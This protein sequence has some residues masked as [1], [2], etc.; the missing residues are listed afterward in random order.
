MPKLTIPFFLF[1]FI[2]GALTGLTPFAVDMYIP[3]I[4]QIS[5]HISQSE[6]IT[7]LSITIFLFISAITQLF[8]G[9][10]SDSFGRRKVILIGICIFI[11]A[12]LLIVFIQN[13]TQLLL[14]RA[15]QAAGGG[16]IAV[17]VNAI[18]RD[19]YND[20]QLAKAMSYLIMIV[21][22]APMIAPI[23]GGLILLRFDWQMIFYVIAFLAIVFG[24]GFYFFIQESHPKSKRQPFN[25]KGIYSNYSHILKQ[26]RSIAYILLGGFSS[27]P[28]FIFITNSASVYQ[29]FLGI[30][31]QQ[32]GFYFGA[33]VLA[34]MASSWIN[35][36]LL[37]RFDYQNIM[38]FFI[39]ARLI[40]ASILLIVS[41]IVDQHILWY[42]FPGVVLSI[43]LMPFVGPNAS[44]ALL[45]KHGKHAGSAS[46]LAGA[47]RFGMGAV[48]GS[49]ASLTQINNNHISMVSW[50]FVMTILCVLMSVWIRKQKNA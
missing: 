7:Q 24:A 14:L 41:L 36:R 19:Y 44:A 12:S 2:L 30:S 22:I 27:A 21:I 50:M 26:P 11:I 37:N 5:E 6:S 32:F 28:M 18:V 9:P 31:A 10:L 8:Y 4:I 38:H 35:T 45:S 33:N 47:A 23:I 48:A 13:I 17:C 43:G 1:L 46:A 3:S 40:P 42:L 29:V 49:L 25:I 16:A 39:W 20:N 34:M 15:L